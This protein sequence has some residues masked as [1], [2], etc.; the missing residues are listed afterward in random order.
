MIRKMMAVM[1]AVM[2]MV[3][4][5]S[6]AN[7]Y[8]DTEATM[9]KLISS[10]D[11]LF[12]IDMA[13]SDIS[14]SDWEV[15]IYTST[16]TGVGNT[17][18][19]FEDNDD[20]FIKSLQFTSDGYGSY[21][22]SIYGDTTPIVNMDDIFGVYFT[23]TTDNGTEYTLYTQNSLNNNYADIFGIY[24]NAGDTVSVKN[25]MGVDLVFGGVIPADPS[26]QAVPI[27]STCLLLGSGIMGLLSFN[28]KQ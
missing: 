25:S 5:V 27:G 17:L 26:T 22:V 15:G 14:Y 4:M 1:I 20:D 10:D 2:C 21:D 6:V 8:D 23:Y 11:S 12:V 19:L 3:Y 9:L 7:A 24:L 28:R 16:G 13:G 18:C